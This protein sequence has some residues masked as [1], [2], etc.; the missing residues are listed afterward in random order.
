MPEHVVELLER[1]GGEAQRLSQMSR[2]ILTFGRLDSGVSGGEADINLVLRDVLQ[3]LTYE[4]QKRSVTVSQTLDHGIPILLLDAGRLKQIFINLVM[5]A[6]HAMET[7]GSLK[8]TT[9]VSGDHNCEIT[10]SDTG[11]GIPEVHIEHIFE[12]FY[13]TK[14]A[15]KGT[16]LGLF[17][18]REIVRAMAGSITVTSSIGQGTC[19][20][21]RFPIT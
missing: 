10:L 14:E 3:L 7:G 9:V 5:N 12:P 6:L 4:V 20:T 15:G 2:S 1:I 8:L 18:T 11:H 13:T 16:G 21:L 17:V 19:F